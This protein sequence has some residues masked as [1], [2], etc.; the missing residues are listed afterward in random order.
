VFPDTGTIQ[1]QS[2]PV[3]ATGL[4]VAGWVGFPTQAAAKS[5]ASTKSPAHAIDKAVSSTAGFLSELSSPNLWL[6]V[7]E[8]ALG[9]VLIAV[10]L[11]RLTHAGPIVEKIASTA[12][13]A[14]V[15]A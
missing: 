2:N 12:G 13:K 1:R 9:V 5:Y 15:L 7:A 8:V 11:A 3:L 14:A 10:G 6:R 4:V